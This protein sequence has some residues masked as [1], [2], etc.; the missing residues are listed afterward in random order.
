MQLHG[1]D[2]AIQ[3]HPDIRPADAYDGERSYPVERGCGEPRE[4]RP[5]DQH[6]R[7][8][9]QKLLL[10]GGPRSA[11]VTLNYGGASNWRMPLAS[12]SAK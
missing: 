6:H 10:M 11:I 4:D 5:L 9:E 8:C 3:A 7:S 2:D 12:L 1:P